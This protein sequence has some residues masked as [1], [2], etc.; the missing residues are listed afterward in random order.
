MYVNVVIMGSEVEMPVSFEK[1]NW[2]RC[3]ST[4]ISDSIWALSSSLFLKPGST[5]LFE[6]CKLVLNLYKRKSTQK[7]SK[8]SFWG[9]LYLQ[10]NN[11]S[12]KRKYTNNFNKYKII[13]KKTSPGE[14]VPYLL[15]PL[16]L[17]IFTEMKV[18]MVPISYSFSEH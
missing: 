2:N 5:F 17:N 7:L 3:A 6:F 16:S 12:K 18:M 8:D 9:F 11:K 14:W 13:V 15:A 1:E 10:L 4:K